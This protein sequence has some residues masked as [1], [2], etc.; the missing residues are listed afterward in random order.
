M[1]YTPIYVY[2]TW[3]AM[4]KLIGFLYSSHTLVFLK[5]KVHV[6]I[7]QMILRT[8]SASRESKNKSLV[9]NDLTFTGIALYHEKQK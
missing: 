6:G 9:D 7:S 8:C 2:E 1:R 5:P 4:Y 3:T